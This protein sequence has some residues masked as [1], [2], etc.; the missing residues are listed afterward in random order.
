MPADL[1]P[2]NGPLKIKEK[3]YFINALPSDMPTNTVK[4]YQARLL[5]CQRNIQACWPS[6]IPCREFLCRCS[7]NIYVCWPSVTET[8]KPL[9]FKHAHFSSAAERWT[10]A[11]P[12][13]LNQHACLSFATQPC[14]S[15]G[16]VLP[17]LPCQLVLCLII[18]C[19]CRCGA[20]LLDMPAGVVPHYQPCLLVWCLNIGHASWCGASLSVLPSS[21]VPHY[22][23]CLLVWCLTVGHAFCCGTSLWPCLLMWYLI[24]SYA[25][26]CGASL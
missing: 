19:A 3:I 4:L 21:V 17:Y 18:N 20:S 1:I 25:C 14:M 12:L 16:V 7:C 9:L 24:I 26:W 13:Q 2:F 23:P 15:A 8:K 22:R 5:H 10:L 11:G 6:A